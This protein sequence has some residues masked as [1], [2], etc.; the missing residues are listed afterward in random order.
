MLTINPSKVSDATFKKLRDLLKKLWKEPIDSIYN[1]VRTNEAEKVSLE[2][3]KPLRRELDGIFF[4]IL[5]I[6]EREQL[7]VYRAVIDLLKSRQIKSK[8]V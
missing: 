6:N 5:G 2:K 7:E 4:E 8:S 1:E 3:V